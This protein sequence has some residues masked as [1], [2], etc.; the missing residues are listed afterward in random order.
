MAVSAERSE[1][2]FLALFPLAAA[3]GETLDAALASAVAGAV[4]IVPLSP[5]ATANNGGLPVLRAAHARISRG[6]RLTWSAWAALTK[7]KCAPTKDGRNYADALAQVAAVAGRHGEHPRLRTDG[8]RFIREIFLCATE[9]LQAYQTH[10]AE[11]GLV[12]FTDQE[13]LALQVLEDP[14]LS[15]RLRERISRVFVDEFQDF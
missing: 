8:A 11:R 1:Q 10:K 14:A 5:S 9:A 15:T 3:S 2:S 7:V 13:A 4:A 6:E 12:D